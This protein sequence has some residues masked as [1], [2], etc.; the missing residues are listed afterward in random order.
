VASKQ[1]VGFIGTGLMGHGMAKNIVTKGYPLTVVAHRNRQPVE[2]LLRRGATEAKSPA[3]AARRADVVFLCVTGSPQVEDIVFGKEGLLEGLSTG[4]IVADS[5]TS[6]PTSTLKVAAAIEAAGAR[7]VD[8]PLVRT[9][10]EAE[11][12]RLV[13][14]TGGDPATLAE[15]RPILETFAEIIVHA[16]PT[17]SG[18]KLKLINNFLA[19]ANATAVAEATVTAMKAGVDLKALTD[20]ATSGGADSVMLRRFA[21]YYLE[22]DDGLAKFAIVNAT[23]DARYYT[24]MAE[25]VPVASLVGEAVHQTLELACIHGF[26][27]NYLPRLVDA[28]ARVNAVAR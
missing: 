25:A 18:H 2:D 17:G 28:L 7:F 3:E 8:T 10:K 12:G 21:K 14:M 9:P 22:G 26:G 11:E 16:G 20:I 4:K 1:R 27:E 13:V 19:L 6:E 23:K 24:H 5:S 15:V